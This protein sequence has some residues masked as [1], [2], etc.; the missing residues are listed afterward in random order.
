M[1]AEYAQKTGNYEKAIQLYTSLAEKTNSINVYNN[2]I[3]LRKS[4]A[5]IYKEL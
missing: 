4:A 5:K 3:N 2:Y 1:Q